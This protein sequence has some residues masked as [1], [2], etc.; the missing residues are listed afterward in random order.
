METHGF[1]AMVFQAFGR[2]FMS[3][4]VARVRREL[5]DDP[6]LRAT[7]LEPHP[8]GCVVAEPL[9]TGSHDAWI[10]QR[11][12]HLGP[13]AGTLTV[14]LS[15]PA[16]SG[17]DAWFCDISVARSGGAT[18][19][20]YFGV[21]SVQAIFAALRG[22]HAAVDTLPCATYAGLDSHMLPFVF[23]DG[24]TASATERLCAVAEQAFFE[25]PSVVYAAH[26]MVGSKM[27]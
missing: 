7:I 15:K 6:D 2:A 26:R 16:T 17:D 3:G 20:R 13:G 24:L 18:R 21:D 27:G 12:L 4:V 23:P 14:F 8:A 5:A 11:E 19:Y 22:A 10:A 1:P 25:H 9:G